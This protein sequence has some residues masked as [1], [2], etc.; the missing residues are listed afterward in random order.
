[1]TL[2]ILQSRIERLVIAVVDNSESLYNT[3]GPPIQMGYKSVIQM[4][5]KAYFFGLKDGS[6]VNVVPAHQRVPQQSRLV[7]SICMSLS[8]FHQHYSHTLLHA[9]HHHSLTSL[10]QVEGIVSVLTKMAVMVRIW[11]IPKFK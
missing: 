8:F 9:R 7:N 2:C 3:N 1:M 4:P 5:R 6:I 10:L 11:P